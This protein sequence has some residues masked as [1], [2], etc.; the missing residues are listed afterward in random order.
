MFSCSERATRSA[1][2]RCALRPRA[3]ATV[4]VAVVALAG[5]LACE[6]EERNFSRAAAADEG[7]GPVSG[8]D[9][10]AY[11]VG[12]GKRL[13]AWFNCVGCHGLGGGGMGPPLMD[14]AWRYGSAP[15]DV[16]ASIM[17]GRPNGMPAFGERITEQQLWRLVAYVRSM[18]GLV[19]K[20]RRPGRND[21]M[22]AK[23]PEVIRD[24]VSPRTV[25][26]PPVPPGEPD[27][28]RRIQPGPAP[29][30]AVPAADT[31]ARR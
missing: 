4:A 24:F 12:E 28:T 10:S 7:P 21:A 20:D 3:R 30:T 2:G 23:A 27:T 8:Y 15:A 13:Y 5:S 26:P 9:E 29:D 31:A 1:P 17:H 6:R 25:G 22:H 11:A 14:R 19:P 16:F 18:S